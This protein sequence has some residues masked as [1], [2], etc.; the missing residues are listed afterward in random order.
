[1]VQ[2]LRLKGI[3]RFQNKEIKSDKKYRILEVDYNSFIKDLHDVI[4]I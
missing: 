2:I 1:M 3:T 4:K